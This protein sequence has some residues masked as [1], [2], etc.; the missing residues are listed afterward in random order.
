MKNKIKGKFSLGKK[1]YLFVAL[2]VFISAF[3]VALMSF[4]INANQ[5]DNYFKRLSLNTAANF[6]TMVDADFLDELADMAVS[7]EYQAVRDEAEL[8]DDDTYVIEYIKE[9]GLW[10]QFNDTRE[11]MSKYL[12]N[13]S[14]I[15]YL[16]IVKW[17]GPDE[18]YDMYL[19]DDTDNNVYM[20]GYFEEREEELLGIDASK[21]VEPV[22][23]HG[24][25]GW[26][27][28]SFVPVVNDEGRVVAQVGCDVAMDDIIRDRI[29]FLSAILCA[30]LVLAAII[31]IIAFSFVSSS[32]VKPLNFI[33][34]ELKKFKP[35]GSKSYR[36]CGVID[37]NIKTHD[38]INDIYT[39]I[40]TMQEEIVDYV[41]DITVIKKDKERAESEIKIKDK[42][43]DEVSKDAYRDSL[44]GVGN[45]LAYEKKADEF[46]KLIG[47]EHDVKFG[48]VMA[49]VNCLKYINDTFGH[50]E[51]DLY[52]KGCIRILCDHFK[53]SPI[54]RIGGDEFVVILTGPDYENRYDIFYDLQ[55]EF[56]KT[57]HYS[58]GE[59]WEKYSAATGMAEFGIIDK[60]FEDVFKRA[61]NAM[62]VCK[63]RFKLLNSLIR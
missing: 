17:G 28:S 31:C 18:L 41:N 3:G 49:D 34:K 26:L 59:P 55:S 7:E 5:I 56:D 13:Y 33:T 20:T 24:D 46:N 52:I 19:V 48:I 35:V 53:H 15:K 57:Y 12:G 6:A 44:T 4:A 23:S 51:G 43:L 39:G 27:C 61:D 37:L 40:K 1:I 38:E 11:K 42:K 63:E 45:H 29:I 9:A 21:T 16:Y 36:E 25:W 50:V 54:F 47:K 8:N 2:A 30:S 60:S 22:I 62:Y 14:D 10:D 32:M 58:D